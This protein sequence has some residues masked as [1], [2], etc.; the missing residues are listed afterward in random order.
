M[1]LLEGICE[2][3][4]E[5]WRGCLGFSPLCALFCSVGFPLQ[6]IVCTSVYLCLFRSV[7]PCPV[8]VSIPAV[9]PSVLLM[10][11]TLRSSIYLLSVYL[12]SS[13]Y[14]SIHLSIIVSSS[15]VCSFVSICFFFSVVLR[16]F[17]LRLFSLMVYLWLDGGEFAF[18]WCG[19]VSALTEGGSSS[20]SL[21]LRPFAGFESLRWIFSLALFGS[22]V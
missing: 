1:V 6:S 13:S 17:L 21:Q 4:L 15:S 3:A 19:G 10:S 8:P 9:S 18:V 14:L 2:G 20:L 22:S 16:R 7:W 11:S 5:D 12:S